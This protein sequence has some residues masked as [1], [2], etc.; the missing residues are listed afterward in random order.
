MSKHRSLTIS[1]NEEYK[2]KLDTLASYLKQ[3]TGIKVSY[4][5]MLKS[6][7]DNRLS[8]IPQPTV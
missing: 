3:T 8:E 6:L 1:M 2:Q 4:A 7:V 5:T